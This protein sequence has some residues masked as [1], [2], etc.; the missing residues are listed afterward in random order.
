MCLCNSFGLVV[1]V[2]DFNVDVHK[3]CYLSITLKMHK[4]VRSSKT[5]STQE[6]SDAALPLYGINGY[7]A[8][9]SNVQ[10]SVHLQTKLKFSV[11]KASPDAIVSV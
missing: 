4:S 11:T 7:G 3:C 5:R 1:Y 8:M 6:F 10:Y 2:T 9:V